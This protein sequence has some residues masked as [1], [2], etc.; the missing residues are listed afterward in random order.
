LR[1]QVKSA[2]DYAYNEYHS[3]V[4]RGNYSK[5]GIETIQNVGN[6]C[7]KFYLIQQETVWKDG[8]CASKRESCE[9]TVIGP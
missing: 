4:Q 8:R 5:S 6:Y 7:R 9:I 3:E 2:V 1:K